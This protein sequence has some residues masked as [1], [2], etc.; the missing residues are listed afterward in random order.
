MHASV[1]PYKLIRAF[2]LCFS[3]LNALFIA[4]Y[5]LVLPLIVNR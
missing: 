4:F 3:L 5:A 1:N 2:L